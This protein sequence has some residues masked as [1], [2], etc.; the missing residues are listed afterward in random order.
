MDASNTLELQFEQIGFDNQKGLCFWTSSL[1]ENFMTKEKVGEILRGVNGGEV[2]QHLA[3][4]MP[5][6]ADTGKECLKLF[7]ILLLFDHTQCIGEFIKQDLCDTHLP[8]FKGK[9][10]RLTIPT[11]GGKT[12]RACC[13][14]WRYLEHLFYIYQWRLLVPFFSFNEKGAP[15][16][17]PLHV[18]TMLPWAPLDEAEVFERKGG[19]GTVERR[20]MHDN[21]HGLGMRL[22]AIK[23]SAPESYT[24]FAVKKLDQVH[25]KQEKLML[26]RLV[27]NGIKHNHLISL[28]TSYDVD[29]RD[30]Y[31]VFPWADCNLEEFFKNE[32]QITKNGSIDAGVMQWF[33]HQVFG[34]IQ[35]LSVLHDPKLNPTPDAGE[36]PPIGYGRHGDI[37]PENILCFTPRD[38]SNGGSIERRTL[39]ISDLGIGEFHGTASRSN[40]PNQG[41]PHTPDYRPPECDLDGGTVSRL[42]DIW[43][44][45]CLFLEMVCWLLEGHDSLTEFEKKRSSFFLYGDQSKDRKVATFFDIQVEENS[46]PHSA[47][48][49]IMVKDAVTK[50][51]SDLHDSELC[52][53][54]IHDL[55]MLIQVDMLV[56]MSPKHTRQTSQMLCKRISKMQQKAKCDRS[57]LTAKCPCK[58]A[59]IGPPNIRAKLSKNATDTI[60][61][62]NLRPSFATYTPRSAS[63]STT[64]ETRRPSTPVQ[65]SN[66]QLNKLQRH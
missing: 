48:Y 33:S 4:I 26:D 47:E 35:A 23:T 3:S 12:V 8:L 1:L 64:H 7:T 50:R 49:I 27:R 30:Y 15:K 29:K 37:K 5:E 53:K 45:G 17:Y 11:S 19:F 65:V 46:D 52:T 56:V 39:V 63:R 21:C 16:H 58:K 14:K 32:S 22:R 6:K 43:T 13:R 40:L 31:L 10:G 55:L 59:H 9:E 2:E 20:K 60:S 57:Y 24:Y 62:L 36:E 28:L 34:I 38:G 18:D 42:W 44:I 66:E 54:Y 41:I 25:F 51:I 61:K